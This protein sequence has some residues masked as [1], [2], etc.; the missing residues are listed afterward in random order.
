[1]KQRS[2]GP[3]SHLNRIGGPSDLQVAVDKDPSWLGYMPTPT[4]E[5]QPTVTSF[6]GAESNL[7]RSVDVRV[8]PAYDMVYLCFAETEKDLATKCETGK[9]LGKTDRDIAEPWI[10]VVGETDV[11]LMEHMKAPIPKLEDVPSLSK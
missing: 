2:E 1:M 11:D 5:V 4:D 3:Q 8:E 7:G 9:V 10:A 6:Q